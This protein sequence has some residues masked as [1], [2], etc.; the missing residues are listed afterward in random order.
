MW[1]EVFIDSSFDATTITIGDVYP[2]FMIQ[3][4]AYQS[5]CPINTHVGY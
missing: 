5:R 2:Q 3:T 1:Y 4:L